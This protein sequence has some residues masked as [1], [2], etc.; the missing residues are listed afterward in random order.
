MRRAESDGGFKGPKLFT[1]LHA[2]RERPEVAGEAEATLGMK[3]NFGVRWHRAWWGA[4]MKVLP[5]VFACSLCVDTCNL[6]CVG[7]ES[8]TGGYWIK[9]EGCFKKGKLL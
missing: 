7:G 4:R 1:S 9:H 2:F 6:D 8:A 5:F 3:A